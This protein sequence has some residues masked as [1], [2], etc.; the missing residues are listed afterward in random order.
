MRDIFVHVYLATNDSNMNHFTLR[1]TFR[2]L[3]LK[4][5]YF[6]GARVALATTLEVSF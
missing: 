4:L 3:N 6:A 1:H 5:T 2:E